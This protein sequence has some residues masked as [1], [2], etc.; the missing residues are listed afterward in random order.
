MNFAPEE[1]FDLTHFAH[2]EIFRDCTEVWEVLRKIGAYVRQHLRPDCL[3]RVDKGAF[4]GPDVFLGKGTVVEPFACVRGPAII[5]EE[6]QIR[7]GAY[8]RG[9]VLVGNRCVVGNSTELKNT[10][11]LDGAV[12]PHY[13]YCG[14]SVLGNRTNL[15][16]GTKLSNFKIAADK[17]VRLRVGDQ[18]ID[19]GLEK[20]GAILGDGALTGCNSVLNPGTVLGRNV[21]V[22][23]CAAIRGYVPHDT[24]V[25]LRQDFDFAPLR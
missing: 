3:G 20:F 21:M 9:D 13:N 23:A 8:V 4:V 15:G 24:V 5:G 6:C 10:L 25:K 18:V 19:T 22:Y 2:R 7:S 16:A 11:M 17:T 14:D 1:F 12:A